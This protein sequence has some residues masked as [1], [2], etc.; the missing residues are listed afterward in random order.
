MSITQSAARLFD[1]LAARDTRFTKYL[2]PGLSSERI[3]ELVAPVGR[4][5][6]AEVI[7]FY[8]HYDLPRGYFYEADQPSF[9]G[10]YWLLGLEDAV[11]FW[12][13]RRSYDFLE[14][15]EHDW[16]PFL[17]EGGNAYLVDLIATSGANHRVISIFHGLEPHVEFLD[18]TAMFDT[19]HAWL[20]EGVLPI[21][22]GRVG[23]DYQGEPRHVAEIAARLNPGID[24]WLSR[25]ASQ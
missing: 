1:L 11:A 23:G 15:R 7:E 4:Q 14:P 20:K 16:F 19:F 24:Y 17:Q 22:D 8:R 3:E 18:L 13:E 6:P 2:R 25:L 9:Y 10:I 21:E 5:L 12:Q